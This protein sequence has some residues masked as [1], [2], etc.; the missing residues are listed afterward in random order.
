MLAAESTSLVGESP[1]LALGT[2]GKTVARDDLQK[3]IRKSVVVLL[4]Q[5]DKKS[6]AHETFHSCQVVVVGRVSYRGP[7]AGACWTGGSDRDHEARDGR[8]G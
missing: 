6:A 1:G 7:V 5:R 2:P 3:I 8:R 4:L